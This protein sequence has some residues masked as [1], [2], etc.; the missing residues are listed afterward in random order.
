ME[1]YSL[2][3]QFPV[4][5]SHYLIHGTIWVTGPGGDLQ[6]VWQAGL[7]NHQGVV[8]R[9]HQGIGQTFEYTQIGVKYG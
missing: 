1:L 9:G 7:L 8:A 2:Q 4:S 6:A 5:N 3:I